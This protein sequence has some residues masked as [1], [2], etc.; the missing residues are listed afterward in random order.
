[1]CRWRNDPL[2][3]G[4]REPEADA[5]DLGTALRQPGAER[6]Q[7]DAIYCGVAG[8]FVK[9][10]CFFVVVVTFWLNSA[11]FQKYPFIII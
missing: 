9:V 2:R 7:I 1:M 4:D 3:R 11:R 10:M 6:Q 5:R 8:G